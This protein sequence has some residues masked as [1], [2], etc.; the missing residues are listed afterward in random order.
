LTTEFWAIIGAIGA[1]LIAA[2]LADNFETPGAWLIVGVVATGYIVSR[3][4]AKAANA[5]S[6]ADATRDF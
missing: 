6:D 2:A 4:L 1:T 3:G 5:H